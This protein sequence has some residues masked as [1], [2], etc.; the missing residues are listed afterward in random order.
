MNQKNSR[1]VSDI[2]R[3]PSSAIAEIFERLREARS[4]RAEQVNRELNIADQG[5]GG[6]DRSFPS[7]TFRCL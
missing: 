5:G 1:L 7:L 3:V 2:G 6:V 4:T